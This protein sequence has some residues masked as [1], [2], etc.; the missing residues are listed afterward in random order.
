MWFGCDSMIAIYCIDFVKLFWE[1]LGRI[2]KF[3]GAEF[4]VNLLIWMAVILGV[5]MWLWDRD[6]VVTN[7]WVK[8]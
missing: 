4:N 2:M 1:F 7:Y 5:Q 8:S 6:R 3:I